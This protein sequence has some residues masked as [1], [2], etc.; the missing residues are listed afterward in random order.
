MPSLLFADDPE[1]GTHVVQHQRRTRLV[2]KRADPAGEGGIR[3]RLRPAEIV[4]ER[5]N[6][7]RRQV[8]RGPLDRLLQALDIVETERE[9]VRPVLGRDPGRARRAPGERPVIRI[10]GDQH[11][12]P[13]G[14]GAR[15]GHAGRRR[16]GT[17]LG[18]QAPIGVR[19]HLDQGLGELDQDRR[20]AVHAVAERGLRA[21]SAL[22]RLVP[23]AEHDRTPGAHHVDEAPAI[24]VLEPAAFRAGEELRVSIRQPRGVQMAPK[25]ARDDLARPRPQRRVAGLPHVRHRSSLS[26]RPDG[27]NEAAVEIVPVTPRP[28]RAALQGG[29]PAAN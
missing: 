2:A 13:R 4:L 11:L 14:L 15:D 8:A 18:E 1:A 26:A 7:D 3:H 5:R 25:A 16:V 21:G 22:D 17:V 29:R 27:G 20:R 6:D 10:G 28:T 24:G 23:V 9:E 12:A 19:H